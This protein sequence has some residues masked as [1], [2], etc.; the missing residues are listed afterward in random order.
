MN[1]GPEMLYPYFLLGFSFTIQSLDPDNF[2][3][4]LASMKLFRR[5]TWEEGMACPDLDTVKSVNIM[6]GTPKEINPEEP[7]T[8]CEYTP[9]KL[10]EFIAAGCKVPAQADLFDKNNIKIYLNGEIAV[11][12]EDFVLDNVNHIVKIMWDVIKETDVFSYSIP[13]KFPQ[14]EIP[15]AD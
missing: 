2:A 6:C 5:F 7:L 4:D 9:I 1:N 12:G 8:V 10:E 14:P 3:E 13:L 11:E 15:N